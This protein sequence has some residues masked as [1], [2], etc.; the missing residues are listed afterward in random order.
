MSPGVQGTTLPGRGFPRRLRY[1]SQLLFHLRAADC[2]LTPDPTDGTMRPLTGQTPKFNR[3]TQA[4]TIDQRGHLRVVADEMPRIR[5]L[6]LDADG[7]FETPAILSEPARTNLVPAAGQEDLTDASWADVGTP[8]VT[9]DAFRDPRSVVSGADRVEDNNAAAVEG[10]TLDVVVTDDSDSVCASVHVHKDDSAIVALDLHLLGGASQ[11]FVGVVAN[12]DTGAIQEATGA[13]ADGAGVYGAAHHSA[14]ERLGDG[15]Y[16]ISVTALNNGSG[17]TTGR[18]G[19][20]PAYATTYQPGREVTATGAA[21]F[22]GLQVEPGDDMTS[23]ARS[24]DSARTAESVRGVVAFTPPPALTL[25]VR[26]AK[27]TWF[28]IPGW[29]DQAHGALGPGLA[30]IGGT[31]GRLGIFSEQGAAELVAQ[32]DTGTTDVTSA[33]V[34]LADAAAVTV[35]A[36]FRDLPDGGQCRIHGGDPAQGFSAWSA[37]A[38]ALAAFLADLTAQAGRYAGISGNVAVLWLKVA[39]ALKTGVEMEQLL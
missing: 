15:Y 12:L 10:R 4:T 5:M 23:Y 39:A 33:S 24:P 11:V 27:P 18:A 30:G 16:R 7:I 17:N 3:T 36:Q 6:D 34:P 20:F 28:G 35:A 37:T 22:W 14:V 8:V 25:A 31:N 19:V 32:I 13:T 2:L 26:I 21:Y 9:A 1:R 29:H 38:G